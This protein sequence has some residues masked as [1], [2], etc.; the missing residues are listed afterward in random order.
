MLPR[1]LVPKAIRRLDY[2]PPAY[3]VDAI[4]LT[5]E[6][7]PGATAVTASLSFRRNPLAPA[8]KD[9]RAIPALVID[10]EQQ[11][12][13][14]VALDG[15]PVPRERYTLTDTTLSLPDPPESGR[16]AIRSRIN[17]AANVALEGLYVSSGVFC[18]QCEPEGF[19][20]ITYFP[21]RP[22]VLAVYTVTI[23]ADRARY[24]V[25]LSNGNR[26]AAGNLPGGRHFVKWH[27]PF[28]KPTYLFALVAGDLATLEDTFTTMSGRRVALAIHSTPSNL[29]RC[30]HAM[31]SL[32]RAM[33]WDEERFGRE[34]DLD[35]FMIFCA[36]DFNMG[37]ME[38][39]GLNVFNSKLVLARPET[40]TDRDYRAIESVVGHEYFHNWTGNRVTCRDWFQ[41]SLKEGLTVFRDQEFSSDIGSRA[42]ER[43]AAV[44]FLRTHQFPE[45]A[46]PMAHPVRPDEYLEINNFYTKTVYEKGA[47]L[48]RMQH[49]LLGPERFRRGMDLYFERHDGQAV[50]CDDFVQAMQDAARETGAIDLTQF[51][52]WYAQAGTPV[53]RVRGAYDAAARS[54]TLEV[55]QHC[56]ATPGQPAKEP[57]HIP[58][59]VGLVGP[60]GRD[61]PLRLAGEDAASGTTRILDVTAATQTFRFDGVPAAPVPSLLR[62][63]SAPAKLEFDYS[64][65][66]L[67]FLAAH[68]RDPVNRWDAAQR[69]FCGAI[70]REAR[71]RA[72]DLPLALDPALVAIVDK[73]LADRDS[74]PA[75]IALALAPPEPGYLAG[76]VDTIDVDALSAARDFVIRE[77]ARAARPALLHGLTSRR[78][79]APYAPA[80]AQVGPRTL[81]NR[82]LHYLG[83]L[84]E[85]ATRALAVA[86]YD[87]ADNMTDAVAALAAVNHTAAPEREAL[88]AR[89]EEQWRGEPL[90]LDKWFAL[91]AMSQRADTL[92]RVQALLSHPKFNAKN[93][94]R[95]RALVGAFALHN[96]QRFHAAD[97]TGY[98]FVAGQ[99][100]A[101]DPVN[102]HLSS[103]LANAFNQWQRFAEP[104]RTLQKAAL[105]RIGQATAL[106]P[107]VR[108]IVARNLA[109]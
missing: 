53:L 39:K 4:E 49:T 17:P 72:A 92:A 103:A 13:V 45:D 89:F 79:T 1:D 84:D 69:S 58:L 48:I 67:A 54:Y 100:M 43:I 63:F 29:D 2:R 16:L 80:Q 19:R 37:A 85:E 14:T 25:L 88:F 105:E 5:F 18:T 42:V 107:D 8:G 87:R 12:E 95:V 41:L 106:S 3:L 9:A 65:D 27:D 24:P 52:R 94:N 32:K 75:L 57:F 44:D 66:D 70:L 97:G 10:G 59:A 35:T 15:V 91:Q 56:P 30:L 31:E 64:A 55:T 36:D 77:V 109:G 76:L 93:P 34:Y 33:R 108:E 78:P 7:D 11:Q 21:D 62:G 101:L 68:D 71:R 26:I 46:G 98:A 51:R 83:A 20:R 23:I 81:R 50:T 40:A 22:D 38:N 60:D 90:V 99:V 6:L 86:Q 102:P 61:L 96:W 104:R 74:D 28:P 73:L 47:E 82:C